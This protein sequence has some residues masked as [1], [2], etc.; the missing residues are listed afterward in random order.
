[1]ERMTG[2]ALNFINN[3][4]YMTRDLNAFCKNPEA[5][6][7][8]GGLN[9]IEIV[10]E[11]GKRG[12][13]L[14]GS[15]SVAAARLCKAIKAES[16]ADTTETKVKV[17]EVKVKVKEVKVK[18]VKVKVKEVKVKVKEV[19]EVKEVKV[20]EVKVKEV[21]AKVKAAKPPASRQA[22]PNIAN[23]YAS[24]L[25]YDRYVSDHTAQFKIISTYDPKRRIINLSGPILRQF[26]NFVKAGIEFGG[27]ID[28]NKDGSFDRAMFGIGMI[29]S[30][31]IEDMFDFEV[32]FHTHPSGRTMFMFAQP[33]Q[34]DIELSMY[35]STIKY[36]SGSP[37][38]QVHI[39]FTP[40]GVYTIYVPNTK[41][42]YRNPSIVEDAIEAVGGYLTKNEEI[43]HL[44]IKKLAKLGI[45]VFR[46]SKVSRLKDV[47]Q[48]EPIN[49]WLDSIPLYIDPQEPIIEA[50]KRGVRKQ[51]PQERQA[52]QLAETL[53]RAQNKQQSEKEK[54]RWMNEDKYVD[55]D[56]N[57]EP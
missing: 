15:R 2:C 13:A 8:K 52:R 57:L 24:V 51:T 14:T 34:R 10:Q 23:R 33:S 28:I 25:P 37:K 12:L 27:M 6:K 47:D 29:R 31:K 44:H 43:I 18:E 19:K 53:Q 46:Y 17:K 20:K 11:L 16:K 42:D 35:A 55:L 48:E 38:H 36:T 54:L 40:E 50:R 26:S 3:N 49:N 4:Y 32:I 30:V 1:M 39:V 21:K 56:L 22:K 41:I 45:Y 7:A 5:S 9:L